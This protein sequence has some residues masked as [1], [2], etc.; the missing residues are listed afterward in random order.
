MLRVVIDTN[1]LP[2]SP[3]S[4][5]AA[6]KRLDTLIEKDIATVLMPSV[7]AEEWRTQR[8]EVLRGQLQ[9]AV[10][11][12][13][14][15][16]SEKH[17]F[18]ANTAETLGSAL[19]EVKQLTPQAEDLSHL[20]LQRLLLRL[21]AQ[22]EDTANHHGKRVLA[23]YFSGNPPFT[24]AKARSDFPD[25][26]LFE[27]VRDALNDVD[28]GAVAVVTKDAN[29]AKHLSGL[30][31]I[32]IFETL[33]DFVESAAVQELVDAA[34]A[35]AQWK[36][37]LPQIVEMLQQIDDEDLVTRMSNSFV[38]KLAMTNVSHSSIP[39]DNGDATVSMVG[40][41]TD[42]QIDWDSLSDYGPGLVR[43]PFSC[44]SEVLLDFYVYYA[45]AYGMDSDHISVTWADPEDH[46]YFDA[47]SHA[48][49][50]VEGYLL[51]TVAEW[52]DDEHTDD[53]EISVDQISESKLE[54]NDDGKVLY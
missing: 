35:E 34:G 43:V 14:S 39:A 13:S 46:P 10:N 15:L 20:L 19:E 52:Q 9:K 24:S 18:S 7:V 21:Q 22:V 32:F 30:G 49:V 36:Q 40:D 37:R 54:E 8:M 47:Q 12:L 53:V 25:A 48:T 27:S 11:A 23:S 6:L 44:S 41:P 16:I 45:D 33:E 51:C 26:F 4:P 5:S 17:L 31:N 1:G 2:L 50:H 28:E 38:D 42:I 3:A 29:L